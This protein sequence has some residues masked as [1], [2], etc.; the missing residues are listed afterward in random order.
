MECGTVKTRPSPRYVCPGSGSI[1][2]DS[3]FHPTMVMWIEVQVQRRIATHDRDR[4]LTPMGV[5]HSQKD[6][7]ICHKTKGPGGFDHQINAQHEPSLQTVNSILAF[8]WKIEQPGLHKEAR[9]AGSAS[10]SPADGWHTVRNVILNC[11]VLKTAMCRHFGTLEQKQNRW[12]IFPVVGENVVWEW[13]P[14]L[15][16]CH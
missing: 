7:A 9:I 11:H 3:R 16:Y 15:T 4:P 6:R 10:M 1:R 5:R 13:D 14:R 12:S 8:F 2:D